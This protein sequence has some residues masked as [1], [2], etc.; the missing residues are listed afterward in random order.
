MVLLKKIKNFILWPYISVRDHL[1]FKKKM[2]QLK[3]A[4]PFIYK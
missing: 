4:D 1:R 3:E 2:K